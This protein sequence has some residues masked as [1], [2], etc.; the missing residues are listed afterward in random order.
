MITMAMER[1]ADMTFHGDIVSLA[2]RNEDFR[3]EVITGQHSQVILMRLAP[4]EEIGEEVHVGVD[5]TLV[6]VAGEGQAILDGVT[7]PVVSNSLY[8][9][10]AG[11]R[12]NFVNTGSGPVKLYTIYAPPEHAPGTVFR[13]KAEADA[14]EPH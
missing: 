11:T 9:V 3:C 6:F 7:S 8:F 5:Q 10:P 2:Q 13:T 12:H 14:A 1:M 4:G